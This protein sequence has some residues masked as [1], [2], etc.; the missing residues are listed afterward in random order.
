VTPALAVGD[1]CAERLHELEESLMLYVAARGELP[2]SLGVL[3]PLGG[4][5]L[6]VT[7][8]VSGKAYVYSPMG[9]TAPG[10]SRRIIVYDA[11]AVHEGKREA[12]MLTPGAGSKAPVM[13][14]V[15]ITEDVLEAFGG[16]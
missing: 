14:V 11:V 3:R 8:P 10:E 16:K 4:G 9:L 5:K 15:L 1:P 2:G 13:D 7:C 12:I 6:E